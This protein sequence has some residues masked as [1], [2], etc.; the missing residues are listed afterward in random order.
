M[1]KSNLCAKLLSFALLSTCIASESV[2]TDFTRIVGGQDAYRGQFPY[3]AL[4]NMTVMDGNAFCG[5]VLISNEWILTAAHCLYDTL[6]GEI[7]LGSLREKNLSEE[8]RVLIEF[9]MDDRRIYPRYYPSV[10][11]NDIGLIKMPKPVEFSEFI[12]PIKLTCASNKDLFDVIVVGNGHMSQEHETIAP[13]LQWTTMKTIS[14]RECLRE[15]PFLLFRKS[16]VC[17]RGEQKESACH[18]DSGG[19]LVSGNTLIGLA[20]F[21]SHSTYLIFIK[22]QQTGIV[23]YFYFSLQRVVILVFHKVIHMFNHIFHG[24][25]Q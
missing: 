4:L 17:A 24:Y 21:V 20:S 25:K 18:G 9:D 2:K 12:Q 8:G 23:K 3:Y 14:Y 1:F 10:I 13:I 7:H 11:W 16:V 22:Q 19:P 5:G 6:D 15:F